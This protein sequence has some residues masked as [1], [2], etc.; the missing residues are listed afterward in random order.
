MKRVSYDGAGVCNCF[1]VLLN[2][3]LSCTGFILALNSV[4]V[5]QV[6]AQ[7]TEGSFPERD[8]QVESPRWIEAVIRTVAVSIGD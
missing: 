6:S 1:D 3:L 2:K 8:E 4:S 5:Y 7:Y